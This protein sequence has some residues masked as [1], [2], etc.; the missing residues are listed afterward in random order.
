MFSFELMPS[1]TMTYSHCFIFQPENL[2]LTS[3]GHIKIAEF[4]S[5]MKH[6]VDTPIR[7]LP[8]ST[9]KINICSAGFS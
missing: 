9:S 6:T 2:P 7:V 8:N 5:M 3:D 4:G 1:A